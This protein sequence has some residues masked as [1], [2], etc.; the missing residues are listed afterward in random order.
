MQK[1]FENWRGFLKESINNYSGVREEVYRS[2]ESGTNRVPWISKDGLLRRNVFDDFTPQNI[3]DE[4]YDETILP[5]LKNTISV[6][7]THLTLPTIL[8]V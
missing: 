8:R 1:L 7:Y 6:S 2:Y 5:Q 4:Y 3:V